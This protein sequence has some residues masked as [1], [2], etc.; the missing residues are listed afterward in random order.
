MMELESRI[1]QRVAEARGR[2]EEA[3]RAAGRKPEEICLVAATKVNGFD[4]VRAAIAA[5]VDACGE[6]R[7]QELLE[8]QALGA[9]AGRPLHFIGHL[10][11]NKVNKVVGLCDLIQS[12]DSEELLQLISRRAAALNITQDILLEVN[13]GGEAAKSGAAP[14]EVEKLLAISAGLPAL[15]VR[16]LMAIP[17]VEEKTGENRKYF[18]AM[19][20]LFVDIT[21]KKYDNS[22]MDILSMGMSTDYADAILEGANMVRLGT[23][24][25]GPRVYR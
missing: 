9:Y 21:A 23:A 10:Q 25:F 8:K 16:G 17:P 11:R 19:Y 4:A 3:A 2:I 12:V 15:R 24:I 13:I 18:Q 6:N 1:A 20:K 7:V 5:G 22:P 14:D